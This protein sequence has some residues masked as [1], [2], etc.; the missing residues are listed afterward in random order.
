MA[1]LELKEA[2]K[3]R[4]CFF[5]LNNPYDA[6]DFLLFSSAYDQYPHYTDSLC[7]APKMLMKP[8]SC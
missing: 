6:R 4:F 8:A 1:L 7:I 2:S 5:Q 3:Q